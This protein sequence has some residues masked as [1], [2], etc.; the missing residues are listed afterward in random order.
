MLNKFYP[1]ELNVIKRLI[2]LALLL[3]CTALVE[4]T[5]GNID[6]ILDRISQEHDYP[7]VSLAV[8]YDHKVY[9]K[10]TGYA[11]I[12]IG[13][14][15][16]NETIFRMYSLTKG[17]TEILANLLVKHGSLDLGLPVSFYLPNIPIHLQEITV[18]QL[19]SHKSG[20]RHYSG[21]DEWLR[22]SQNHCPSPHMAMPE[23]INDSLI[24]EPGEEI[25]Y[26]SF[27]Y[28]L[29]SAVIE[30]AGKK[31]FEELMSEFIFVPSKALR[32]ELDNP[33][34]NGRLNVTSFYEPLEEGYIEAP[35]VDNS[36]KFGAGAINAS[37]ESLVKVFSHF[38]SNNSA[39]FPLPER[40]SMG[41]EGLGGRS[42][43]IAYPKENLIVIVVANARGG[44]LLPYA[45]EI[46][47]ALLK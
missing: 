47:E 37:P 8:S 22:L 23:F 46:A 33:K 17:V 31:P 1:K 24:S 34:N 38:Y 21:N 15:L 36:C 6:E 27:G 20:I 40:L 5:E 30:V 16:N 10:Q 11:D 39:D 12:A 35:F 29:L 4:A 41:G 13:S 28:V 44:N 2:L 45:T 42:A 19:L 9:V 43:L 14:S 7:G 26:T 18:Q 25:N 32:I 3:M